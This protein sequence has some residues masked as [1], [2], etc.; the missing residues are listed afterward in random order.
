MDPVLCN[1][2]PLSE[3][4]HHHE[5]LWINIYPKTSFNKCGTPKPRARRESL[6]FYWRCRVLTGT[7]GVKDSASDS[8]LLC[9][10]DSLY[11]KNSSYSS[12]LP[13]IHIHNW[14]EHSWTECLSPTV[15]HALNNIVALWAAT[16]NFSH[17]S[18]T[19]LQTDVKCLLF[20]WTRI[21]EH[22]TKNFFFF[23]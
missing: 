23:F 6:K 15:L 11:T 14:D 22:L 4:W 18:E 5:T 3:T 17:K 16:P 12:C 10:F 21:P 2:S 7:C 9:V 8:G 19:E 13:E 20:L 1:F